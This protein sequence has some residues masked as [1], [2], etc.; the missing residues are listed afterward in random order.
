MPIIQTCIDAS[1]TG[2]NDPCPSGSILW[3]D[4]E[5]MTYQNMTDL[6]LTI[7]LETIEVIFGSSL[8]LFVIGI[9]AGWMVNIIKMAR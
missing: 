3:Q 4:V 9:G 2:T 1:V 6:F 8:F 7:D 5:I